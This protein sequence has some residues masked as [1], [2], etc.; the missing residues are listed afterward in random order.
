MRYIDEYRHL[1]ESDTFKI[2]LNLEQ[3]VEKV[4]SMNY[5]IHRFLSAFVR[6][7]LQEDPQDELAKGI[8]GLLKKGLF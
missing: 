4:M 3:I 1:N 5:G 2:A 8:E 7:R 6:L